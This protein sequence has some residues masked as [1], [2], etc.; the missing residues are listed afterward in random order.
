MVP[1]N[2]DCQSREMESDSPNTLVIDENN[3]GEKSISDDSQTEPSSRVGVIVANEKVK[4]EPKDDFAYEGLGARIQSN[5]IKREDTKCPP[6]GRGGVIITV[7]SIT[8]SMGKEG[9]KVPYSP[10]QVVSS[11]KD[12]SRTM[13]KNKR[14]REEDEPTSSMPELGKSLSLS[15]R[16]VRKIRSSS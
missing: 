10:I 4:K 7:S 2:I 8:A 5:E 11:S 13:K 9:F 1:T 15:I 3:E 6:V 14:E 12:K 16:A